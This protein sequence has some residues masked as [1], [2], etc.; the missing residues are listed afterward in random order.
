MWFNGRIPVFQTGDAGSIPATRSEM[1]KTIT[2][3]LGWIGVLTILVA[4]ALLNFGMIQSQSTLYQ[5]LNIAGSI[6]IIIETASKKDFQPMTLNIV[7]LLIAAIAL[8]RTF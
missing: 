2:N 7:W 6:L 8:F 3:F 4:Y 1:N 5:W